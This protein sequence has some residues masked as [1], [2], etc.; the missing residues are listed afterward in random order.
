MAAG[1]KR[2]MVGLVV[3]LL[4]GGAV[5][6]YLLLRRSPVDE[7]PR[8]VGLGPVP[9]KVLRAV[10]RRRGAPVGK[11]YC[12]A[13]EAI[14]AV[15][16][17]YA[18]HRDGGKVAHMLLKEVRGS[19]GPKG[20]QVRRP[21]RT[22]HG[23]VLTASE[24]FSRI[25]SKARPTVYS[26]E[27]AC[28]YLA[29]A[30]A[31]GLHA[32]MAEIHSH[33]DKKGPADPLGHVGHFGVAIYTTGS[34]SGRP[35][36]LV[37]PAR[38]TTNTAKEYDVITDLRTQAHGMALEALHLSERQGEAASAIERMDA[39][40]RLAP[41]SATLLAAK[42]MLLLKSGGVAPALDS[43]LAARSIREDAPRFLLVAMCYTQKDAAKG[44]L[45]R[46]SSNMDQAINKDPGY[47]LAYVM[48]ADLLL[49]QGKVAL[50]TS[51]LDKAQE[52]EPKLVE[53]LQARALILLASGKPDP[54]VAL[55]RKAVKQ[56]P[57]D[58]QARFQL[59]RVLLQLEREDEAKEAAKGWLAALPKGSRAQATQLMKRFETMF[60]K[61][62]K[63]AQPLPPGGGEDPLKLKMPGS[64]GPGAP[65][66]PGPFP[67]QDKK[68]HL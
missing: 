7:G 49:R 33:S 36:V 68:L 3:L 1:T 32:V 6:L 27:L 62:K 35:A 2:L 51:Q 37:D 5:T 18:R 65:G 31:S 52:I 22:K 64:P 25:R 16:R 21:G 40:L 44:D 63:K 38:G 17:R 23:Q 4:V 8:D 60:E 54:A 66:L 55:L 12:E 47:A 59:W 41:R 29:L 45:S 24:L 67:S 28:L 57:V 34:F 14:R 46:A 9:S 42:G 30:R 15:G 50:A 48:K 53:A 19:L 58:D 61:Y 20:M 10:A 26:Y 11:I 43:F 39:A 13:D 56:D